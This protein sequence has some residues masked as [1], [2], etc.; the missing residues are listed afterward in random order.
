MLG[1]IYRKLLFCA[2]IHLIK[3]NFFRNG[4]GAQCLYELFC[5]DI[6]Y[7]K[8]EPSQLKERIFFICAEKGILIGTHFS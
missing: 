7:I 2:E 5:A 6:A 4:L 3:L 1:A 8:L